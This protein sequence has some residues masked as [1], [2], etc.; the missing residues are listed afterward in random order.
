MQLLVLCLLFTAAFANTQQSSGCAV[1][2]LV[3]SYVDNF[4]QDN[5]TEQEIIE[6]L[7]AI[8]ALLGGNLEQECDAMVAQYVPQM[9]QWILEG[10]TPT[11]FCTQVGLCS[12]RKHRKDEVH[13]LAKR[14]VAQASCEVCELVVKYVEGY[15]QN[16]QTEQQIIQ[17]LEQICDLLGPLSQTCD[18]FVEQYTPQLIDWIIA[19]N[20]PQA[21]CAQVGLC[22]ARKQ[23]H[24]V[25]HK[26]TL[27]QGGGCSVCEL[28]VQYIEGFIAT[29]Q[30]E[31]QIIDQLDQICSLLGPLTQE[32][33]DF[34]ASYVPQAIDWILKN[35]DPQQF[36]TQAGLCSFA[37][38]NTVRRADAKKLII[39][40]G[41][42]CSICETLAAMLEE[43]LGNPDTEHEIEDELSQICSQLPAPFDAECKNIVDAYLPQLVQWIISKENPTVLCS[44]LSLC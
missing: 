33:D 13:I 32:C 41:S 1:C 15:V 35:E 23:H 34:V 3:V 25:V 28:L 5:A 21:F 42:T 31:Q 38:V 44:Q 43:F 7:D 22:S 39:K 19:G 11:A 14:D 4:I 40:S 27:Q 8:C 12:F 20:S 24:A 9:I 10:E 29:N 26:R 16:N 36:C 2:Q 17:Q 18:Q 6:E 37:K 30:S